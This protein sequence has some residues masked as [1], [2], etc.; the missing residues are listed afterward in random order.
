M[1]LK[2]RGINKAYSNITNQIEDYNSYNNK[3]IRAKRS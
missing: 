3:L 1:K 2:L